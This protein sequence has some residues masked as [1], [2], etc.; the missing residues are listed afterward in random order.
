MGNSHFLNHHPMPEHSSLANAE[1]IIN[2]MAN[3]EFICINEVAPGIRTIV[4]TIM[5]ACRNEADPCYCNDHCCKKFHRQKAL[6][7]GWDCDA[8]AAISEEDVNHLCHRTD[9][10]SWA[11]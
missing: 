2:A 4:Y 3:Q 10:C 7:W 11:K 9:M 6:C 5:K 8:K 1:N